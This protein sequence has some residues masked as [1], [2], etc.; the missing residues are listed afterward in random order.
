MTGYGGEVSRAVG[1]KMAGFGESCR[2]VLNKIT[3][4]PLWGGIA[5]GVLVLIVLLIG[6][7]RRAG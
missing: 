5:L 3:H 7:N 6:V 2:E 1:E 4:D